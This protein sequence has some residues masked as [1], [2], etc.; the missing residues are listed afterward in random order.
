MIRWR[1]TGEMV[2]MEKESFL[3]KLLGRMSLE[4]KA[5]QLNLL[6]GG[7]DSTGMKIP[8]DLSRKIRDGRCGA[9]L[10]V[11]TPAA[12]RALQELA[13]AGPNAIP[14]LFGYDVIHGHRTIFPIP[15]GLACSWNLELIR[16]TAAAAAAEAT[17]DG[18]H[19][20]FSPMV[21][22][23]QD[24]RWGRVAE[25][26]GEDPWLGCRIAEAM[27]R[28]YQGTDIGGEDSVIACVKHF[29]LYGASKAGRDYHEVDMSRREMEETHFPPYRAAVD[30]GVRT[31]M[32]SFNV[33][34]G[35]PA[36]ANRDLLTSVLRGRW[37]FAGWVVTDY[38]AVG[39]MKN[40]GTAADDAD[41]AAQA[42]SAGADMDM[43]SEA[44]ETELP[45]LVRSGLIDESLV[46]DAVMRILESKWDMGLFTNPFARCDD[47]RAARTHLSPEHRKLARQAAR[48]SIVLLKNS[49]DLL[50]LAGGATIAVIGPLADSRRDM[51]GCWHAAGDD[52][53]ASSPL[54]GFQALGTGKILHAR[55]C[56][57]NVEDPGLLSAAVAIAARAEVVVLVLGESRE[58]YGEAAS[59]TDIRLPECQR[60]LSDAVLETGKPCV[61][62]TISGRP[63]ELT[64]EDDGFPAMVHAWAPGTEGGMALAEVLFGEFAPVGKLTMG[65]PRRVG[66]LPMTYR[67]KPVGRPF[68]EGVPYSSRYLDCP[69]DALFPFG[70]GLTYGGIELGDLIL[71]HSE[72]AAGGTVTVSIPL[73]NTSGFSVTETPQLYLRDLVASVSRPLKE[74]RGYQRVTLAAG[75]TRIVSFTLDDADLAFPGADFQPVVEPGEFEVMVGLDSR[76]L[77]RARFIR[78]S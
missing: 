75:E 73:T 37:G 66:Q 59:R 26:A 2:E 63:L 27:I 9:V 28:G 45:E 5:G 47:A 57:V 8:E 32:S 36:T 30:A 13:L 6:A 42:L 62:V 38:T 52:G 55:G 34:D 19:W 77:R 44:F 14:L 65:F 76:N 58:M 71:D 41:C 21:D 33:I 72:M 69:N 54:D 74:L 4:E 23:C 46:D 68:Q 16:E 12:T 31:V 78:T 67:E 18:L 35:I 25:G 61:L 48:E 70:H 60:R 24:A 39:E 29:A 7:M 40:H 15:L 17:A 11:Y 51:L 22:L 10:N 64:A 1:A 49:G 20:V 50:P 53:I 3:R 56:G 43:M